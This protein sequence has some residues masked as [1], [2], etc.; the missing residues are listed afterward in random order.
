MK[1]WLTSIFLLPLT[2]RAQ[3]KPPDEKRKD[4]TAEESKQEEAGHREKVKKFYEEYKTQDAGVRAAA[5]DNLCG[6]DHQETYS[7]MEGLLTAD[8]DEIRIKAVHC[9][10]KI[11]NPRTASVLTQAIGHLNNKGKGKVQGAIAEALAEFEDPALADFF[12]RLIEGE[13]EP[14]KVAIEW[15]G[16]MK[17]SGAIEKLLHEWGNIRNYTYTV[18]SRGRGRS[19]V[20][21]PGF[22]LYEK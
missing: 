22:V 15:L 20:Y 11:K 2:L 16:R 17:V 6:I 1:W 21:G 12:V 19:D 5:I 4:P 7:I 3:D 10:R 18:R 13:D 8:T 14:A 9:L